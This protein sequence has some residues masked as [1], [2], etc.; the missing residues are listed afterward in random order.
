MVVMMKCPWLQWSHEFL[1]IHDARSISFNRR[2][3]ALSAF[4]KGTDNFDI[5][6]DR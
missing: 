3:F 2:C 1:S 4:E 6:S 5:G